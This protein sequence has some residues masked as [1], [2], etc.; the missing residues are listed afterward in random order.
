MAKCSP[1]MV[2][3][4]DN[5]QVDPGFG[6]LLGQ[7]GVGAQEVET[8]DRARV[9]FEWIESWPI[10]PPN[11]RQSFFIEEDEDLMIFSPEFAKPLDG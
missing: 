5:Q 7:L 3:L 2:S 4:V 6:G 9:R 11:V 10:F 1:Q 8:H